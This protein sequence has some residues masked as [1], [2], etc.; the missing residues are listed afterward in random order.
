MSDKLCSFRIF[1]GERWDF[2]GHGCSKPAKHERDGRWFCGMHTP[3]SI[4]K[5]REVQ[6]AKVKAN[7]TV[8]ME[9][10]RRD[11]ERNARAAEWPQL[12]QRIAELEAEV[13][14]LTAAQQRSVA[15]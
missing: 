2:G 3:E 9:K 11:D 13:A 7:R 4:Q 15:G 12:K 8:Q 6:K 10:Y 1:S 5:R 14:A